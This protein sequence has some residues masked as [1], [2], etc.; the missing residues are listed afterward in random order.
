MSQL[1]LLEQTIQRDVD[2]D[3]WNSSSS[4]LVVLCRSCHTRTN[5]DREHW[6][7][8]FRKELATNGHLDQIEVETKPGFIGEAY[9]Q[10]ELPM[11]TPSSM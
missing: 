5:F 9:R 10:L 11:V 4:N 8:Y 6:A 2:Y 3:P 1:D 7:K